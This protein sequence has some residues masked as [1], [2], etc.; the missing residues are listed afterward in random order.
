MA[1][2]TLAT[3]SLRVGGT[4]LDV[5][6]NQLALS[7]DEGNS[8]WLTAAATIARP[9]DAIAELLR[10][11]QKSPV[12]LTTTAT[13]T[14]T[15]SLTL[16]VIDWSFSPDDD[17]ITLSLASNEYQMLEYSPTGD[18]N[19]GSDVYQGSTAAIVNRVLTTTYG[20]ATSAVLSGVADKP[21]KTFS[22]VKNMIPNGSFEAS[23]GLW[24]AS[25]ATL[26]QDTARQKFGTY[27]LRI[28]PNST[29][30]SSY[31]TMPVPL[32]PGQTYTYSAYFYTAGTLQSGTSISDARKLQ[33][34]G[35]ITNGQWL[36]RSAQVPNQTNLQQRIS[37]T[38]TVPW[39]V[40]D[41]F[42]RVIN[43]YTNT[44]DNRINVDGI[45][46]VEGDGMD[47]NGNP[48]EY[49]DGDNPATSDYT[50]TWDDT[51]RLSS[52][53]RTAVLDRG[54]DVLTWSGGQTADEFLRPIVE[55]LGWRLFLD[56][57]ARW[58]LTDN[59]YKVPG[60]VEMR[61]GSTLYAGSEIASVQDEDADG[62]PMAADAV[63][64]KYSWT[65]WKGVE[66]TKSDV[67]TTAG[68]S[69]PYVLEK[70]DTPY[71]GPG[72]AAYLLARLQART[73]RL[74]AI[75]RPAWSARPGMDAIVT[76]PNRPSASGY[77]QALTW[78]FS[79][80]SM[81]VTTKGL[82]TLVTGSIGKAPATQTIGSV[83]STIGAYTN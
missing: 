80:N 10:P 23:S 77:V 52:S 30:T 17:R 27:S 69:R 3:Y 29:S 54:P 7:M 43:G 38:F 73:R 37:M 67:A 31:I 33:V 24:T 61:S 1:V 25:Q 14:P 71:P 48:I 13:G 6:E 79:D 8:P 26:L 76:L 64:V 83:A 20:T 74:D 39:N 5:V 2:L 15:L 46:L 4:A 66:R 32:T 65:D 72:Q 62:F 19:L 47:T 45:L 41:T 16:R 60:Q 34:G 44:A 68:Y 12:T 22:E 35:T 28:T 78:A 53:T 51:A 55:S 82:V 49:F 59:G 81:T 70:E 9:S 56:E 11:D 57:K 40:E 36:V 18:I 50:Y 63:I 58:V 21:F 75:G 42:V